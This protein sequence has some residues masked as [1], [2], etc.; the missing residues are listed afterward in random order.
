MRIACIIP[1]FNEEHSIKKISLHAKKYCKPVIVVDDGSYDKTV[2]KARE[3]GAL[4][5]RHLINLGT[6]AALST[7][8][9]IALDRGA[10]IIITMDG[11]GQHD[12]D[13][14]PLLL[15]PILDGEADVII[16]SRFL[17]NVKR[18]PFHK[19]VGN[20]FL[21]FMNSILFREKCTDS[22]SGFRAYSRKVLTS[23]LHES[24]DYSWA[25]EILIH[26]IRS[27]FNRSEVP[28][29]TIYLK[30]RVKGTGLIDGLKIFLR[31]L[32][33]KGES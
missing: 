14:I 25:S 30:E 3:G 9:K 6:G 28:I 12:P 22:Q 11:D 21:S 32:S 24:T 19:R 29:K 23:I 27:E 15:K 16:G 13:D 1:A 20:Q 10:E 33:L 18:M 7:G 31:I 8:F 4:V 5:V 26:I 17:G 2:K